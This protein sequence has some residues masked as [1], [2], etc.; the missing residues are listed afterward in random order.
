MCNAPIALPHY[1][2]LCPILWPF[3]YF[4]AG[5]HLLNSFQD[6]IQYL[7]KPLKEDKFPKIKLARAIVVWMSQQNTDI[8]NY[9]TRNLDT[10]RGLLQYLKE[11]RMSYTT[12]YTIL[13]RLVWTHLHYF[14]HNILHRDKRICDSSLGVSHFT[15]FFP[16]TS[17]IFT[18]TSKESKYALLVKQIRSW[19]QF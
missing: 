7:K 13:C 2:S 1:K 9:G 4:K 11:E 6:L 10:P 18:F 19:C 8:V 15:I 14:Q 3:C 16:A 5:P 17:H 12:C